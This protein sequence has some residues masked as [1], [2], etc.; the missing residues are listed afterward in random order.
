M[1]AIVL[2]ILMKTLSAMSI[3]RISAFAKIAGKTEIFKPKIE[4]GK[5]GNNEREKNII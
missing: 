2:L 4:I 1:I 3:R 5:R